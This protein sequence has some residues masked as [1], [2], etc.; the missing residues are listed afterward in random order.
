MSLAGL[1]SDGVGWSTTF[2]SF[3]F[4]DDVL[5]GAPLAAGVGLF[6]AALAFDCVVETAT[7]GVAGF[8]EMV[9]ES[10]TAD[11][12]VGD[13]VVLANGFVYVARSALSNASCNGDNDDTFGGRGNFFADTVSHPGEL[14]PDGFELAAVGVACPANAVD[15][16]AS[17][18]SS[19]V[20]T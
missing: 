8:A 11:A 4:V 14:S 9:G 17:M 3:V 7:P 6:D 18:E 19:S 15:N 5:L 2:D 13:N 20:E 1:G 10:A 12:C 16:P